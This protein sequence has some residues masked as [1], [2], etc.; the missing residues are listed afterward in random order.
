MNIVKRGVSKRF[1]EWLNGELK[2]LCELS[3]KTLAFPASIVCVDETNALMTKLRDYG[4]KPV[5]S[6]D[7]KWVSRPI[8]T[9]RFVTN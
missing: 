7:R 8:F 1:K 5:I 3:P 9:L 2:F 4:W 6:K